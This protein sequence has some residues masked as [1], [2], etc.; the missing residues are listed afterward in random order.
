M[1]ERMIDEEYGRGVRL[2]K[3]KD[4]FVDVT[5]ELATDEESAAEQ[6]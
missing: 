1:E 2:R 3:T 6:E 5:D 4:G